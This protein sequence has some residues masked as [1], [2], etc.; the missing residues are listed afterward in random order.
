MTGHRFRASTPSGRQ[1]PEVIVLSNLLSSDVPSTRKLPLRRVPSRSPPNPYN[2]SSRFFLLPRRTC[3]WPLRLLPPSTASGA[4]RAKRQGIAPPLPKRRTR[5]MWFF[6]TAYVSQAWPRCDPPTLSLFQ[7]P[8]P[9]PDT[10]TRYSPFSGSHQILRSGSYL[11]VPFDTDCASRLT[12]VK[13]SDNLRFFRVDFSPY[14]KS[15]SASPALPS[16]SH[17]RPEILQRVTRFY[18]HHHYRSYHPRAMVVGIS[19]RVHFNRNCGGE[20]T[21]VTSV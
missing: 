4:P 3:S 19:T 9:L 21:V 6:M 17:S 11:P 16:R 20:Q 12:M 1:P 7:P 8:D 5:N 2:P 13:A 18:S 14:R 10:S 15:S